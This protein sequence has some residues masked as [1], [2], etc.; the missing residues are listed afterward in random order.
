MTQTRKIFFLIPFIIFIQACH[1]T[2]VRSAS[3]FEKEKVE[4]SVY[5]AFGRWILSPEQAELV[6]QKAL[7][8]KEY[9]KNTVI[10]EGHTDDVGSSEYNLQLGDRRA[11][12]VK[13]EL[14]KHGIDP[15]RLVVI[16]YGEESPLSQS[17]S[18]E[19]RQHERRVDFQVK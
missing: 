11:R 5:F 4:G 9:Q 7:S 10:L 15:A 18:V 14:T 2:P 19:A 8:L 1:Q 12:Q 13:L 6:S 17:H 16:S 3:H